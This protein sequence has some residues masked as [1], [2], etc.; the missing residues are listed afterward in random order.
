M[1]SPLRKSFLREL[2][3]RTAHG[4]Q[5]SDTLW[6]SLFLSWYIP[7]LSLSTEL[8]Q[9]ARIQRFLPLLV[10]VK[11]KPITLC[12]HCFEDS[13]KLLPWDQ[14]TR[15]IPWLVGL[16]IWLN[17]TSYLSGKSFC[18]LSIRF[19]S[20]K[21]LSAWSFLKALSFTSSLWRAGLCRILQ[22]EWVT[23][24]SWGLSSGHFCTV[25]RGDPPALPS[26][27]TLPIWLLHKIFKPEIQSSATM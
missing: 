10:A 6:M 12:W 16:R 3:T 11:A 4:C 23:C 15:G 27:N 17:Q 7:G 18:S 9:S 20:I 21:Y 13:A 25:D 1:C 19:L 5:D 14:P 26:H 24:L 8:A 22:E 2:V